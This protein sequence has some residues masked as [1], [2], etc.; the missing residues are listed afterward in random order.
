MYTIN[1]IQISYITIIIIGFKRRRREPPYFTHHNN[2]VQYLR[3]QIGGVVEGWEGVERVQRVQ[4]RVVVEGRVHLGQ[5]LRGRK[6]APTTARNQRRFRRKAATLVRVVT[7][8]AA[9]FLL[10]ILAP[11]ESL[12]NRKIRPGFLFLRGRDNFC[13]SS[14]E[15]EDWKRFVTNCCYTEISFDILRNAIHWWSQE[16]LFPWLYRWDPYLITNIWTEC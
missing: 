9:R 7:G 8:A 14:R 5:P 1:F 10:V 4:M 2:R 12:K 16:D 6:T 13:L 11:L 15:H 3:L